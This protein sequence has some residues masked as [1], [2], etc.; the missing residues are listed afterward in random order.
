MG[1]SNDIDLLKIVSEA[2]PEKVGGVLKEIEK[3]SDIIDKITGH[4][5]R[6]NRMGILPALIRVWGKKA[7]VEGD[8]NAPL[9]SPLQLTAASPTHKLFFDELNEQAEE[10]IKSFLYQNMKAQ[11]KAEQPVKS[12][13]KPPKK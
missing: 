5:A 9:S 11:I 6:F 2:D 1:E 8:I 4:I 10:V 3:Y 7:G 13:G 12:K